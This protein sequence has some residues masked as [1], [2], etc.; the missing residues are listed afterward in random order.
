M[1]FQAIRAILL[2]SATAT[3]FGFFRCRSSISHCEA[4]LLR[5]ALTCW[6]RAVAPTTY[7]PQHFVTGT[8]DNPKPDLACSRMVFWRE[9]NPGG[10]ISTRSRLNSRGSGVFIIKSDAPT[11]PTPGIRPGAC[12]IHRSDATLSVFPRSPSFRQAGRDTQRMHGKKLAGQ[13]RWGLI[14]R[15]PPINGS[16]RHMPLAAAMPNSMANPRMAL[17]SCVRLRMGLSRK[18]DQHQCR[19]LVRSLHG[20]EAHRWS[21]RR[22]RQS[23]RVHRVVLAAFYVG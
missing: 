17:A 1:S 16:I 14:S 2:A 7:A 13:C 4:C 23:L 19:L 9:P 15:N 22:L 8:G 18:T 21:A 11:G 10:K 5:P 12:C 3:N 20:H 6:R